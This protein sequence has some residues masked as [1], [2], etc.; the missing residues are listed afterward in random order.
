MLGRVLTKPGLEL[1]RSHDSIQKLNGTESQRTPKLRSKLP[2]AIRYSGFFGV[3]SGSGPVGDFS[4]APLTY[5]PRNKAG[6]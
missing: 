6:Y 1:K 3:L 4:V 5:P 2:L